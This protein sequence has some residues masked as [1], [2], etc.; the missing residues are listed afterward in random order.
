MPF[1]WSK[2][3]S[4]QFRKK[5]QNYYFLHSCLLGDFYEEVMLQ[6]YKNWQKQISWK[7][8]IF[9][10][11]NFTPFVGLLDRIYNKEHKVEAF[12]HFVLFFS[13]HSL[14]GFK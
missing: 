7:W 11:N 13:A 14:G 5:I 6:K 12:K 3:L 1:P 8:E 4:E 9:F 2:K 10:R